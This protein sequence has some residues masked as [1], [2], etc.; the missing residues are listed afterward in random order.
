MGDV[1]RETPKLEVV[2]EQAEKALVDPDVGLIAS[3]GEIPVEPNDPQIFLFGAR[4]ADT[5]LGRCAV[6]RAQCGGAGLTRI[7]AKAAA[8]GEAVERYCCRSPDHRRF[9]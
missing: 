1:E 4:V 8:V 2:I 6:H 7:E 9:I 3:L 5:P